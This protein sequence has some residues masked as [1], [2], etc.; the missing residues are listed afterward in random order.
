MPLLRSP[1]KVNQTR[2]D[3][4]GPITLIAR[5]T[6]VPVI[7][8]AQDRSQERLLNMSTVVCALLPPSFALSNKCPTLIGNIFL[9]CY[10]DN[11]SGM[12]S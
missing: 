6:G 1:E 10:L 4:G 11:I 9:C 3:S 8:D 2:F 7:R 12:Y 5:R